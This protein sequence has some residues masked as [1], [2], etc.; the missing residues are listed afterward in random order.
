MK[1]KKQRETVRLENG[2]AIVESEDLIGP[3]TKFKNTIEVVNVQSEI[4][5]SK[6]R[7]RRS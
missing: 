2:R 4:E 7:I 6:K 3:N 1:N 5:K